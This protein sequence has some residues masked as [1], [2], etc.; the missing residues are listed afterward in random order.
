M[1]Q[2]RGWQWFFKLCA[3]LCGI[4]LFFAAIFLPES[5]WRRP[6]A[7]GENAA[8]VD[9]AVVEAKIGSGEATKTIEDVQEVFHAEHTEA[10]APYAG[11]YVK[12]LFAFRNRGLEEQGL[13]KFPRRFV[14][15][16]QFLMVPQVVYAGVS[17]GLIIAG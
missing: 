9:Q 14:E 2:A 13:R 7:K 1:I 16:F 4:N 10:N 5:T 15:P 3:I 12:D 8:E 17:F 11:S 6:I